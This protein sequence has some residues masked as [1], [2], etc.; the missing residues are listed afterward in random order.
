MPRSG[1]SPALNLPAPADHVAGPQDQNLLAWTYD[2]VLQTASTAPGAGVLNLI[3][4][5]VYRACPVSSILL[6][7]VGAG[8]GLTSGQNAVG[9][10]GAGGTLIGKSADQ[11]SANTLNAVAY[12]AALS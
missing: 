6:E 12:W 9:L 8:S 10:Y 3:R 2:P 5:P 1:S 4:V 11:S 7:V